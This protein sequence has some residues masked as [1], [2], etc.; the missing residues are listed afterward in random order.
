MFE[1]LTISN[2]IHGPN[3]IADSATADLEAHTSQFLQK[4]QLSARYLRSHSLALDSL[5]F[6]RYGLLCENCVHMTLI[7]LW[8]LSFLSTCITRC[9]LSI[10]VWVRDFA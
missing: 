5:E 7:T 3:E 9:S 4:L 2:C 10:S 6:S 1:H 8:R